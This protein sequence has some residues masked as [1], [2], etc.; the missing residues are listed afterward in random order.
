MDQ[1]GIQYGQHTVRRICHSNDAITI[2]RMV[3][4]E[5]YK[6]HFFGFLEEFR[7]HDSLNH[8]SQCIILFLQDNIPRMGHGRSNHTSISHFFGLGRRQDRDRMRL[9][10][11][12][13]FTAFAFQFYARELQNLF[14][15]IHSDRLNGK[16]KFIRVSVLVLFKIAIGI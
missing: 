12:D 14:V 13:Q 9:D 7:I 15:G 4:F 16:F 3:L 8:T 10:I 11:F 2:V 5:P 6:R 1:L